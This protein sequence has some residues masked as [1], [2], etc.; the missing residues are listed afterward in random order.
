MIKIV[1]GDSLK[2][3][4]KARDKYPTDTW[5]YRAVINVGQ[6]TPTVYT[7]TVNDKGDVDFL[8][9]A[10]DTAA[11][12]AGSATAVLFVES[13]G[14]RYTLWGVPVEVTPNI[15]AGGDARPAVKRILDALDAMI[16]GKATDDQKAITIGSKQIVMYG[17]AELLEWRSYYQVQWERYQAANGIRRK[18][19]RVVVRIR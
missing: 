13:D 15:A 18:G 7:G 17:P 3:T 10:A 9:P 6:T 2:W 1:A 19:S 16:L 11:F 12:P 4:E 8:V 5:T 14:E